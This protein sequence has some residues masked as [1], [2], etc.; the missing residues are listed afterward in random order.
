M[1]WI[2]GCWCCW[3]RPKE[4]S[5]SGR[6]RLLLACPGLPS[7]SANEGWV[8]DDAWEVAE[9]PAQHSASCLALPDAGLSAAGCDRGVLQGGGEPATELLLC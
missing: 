8:E 2:W 7:L 1:E 4:P 6:G 5:S 9:P 3:V